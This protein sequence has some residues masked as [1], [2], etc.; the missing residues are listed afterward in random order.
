MLKV[1]I[2]YSHAQGTWVHD[3]LAPCLKAAGAEVL[4]DVD[5][6]QLGKGVVGQ[7]NA[8]QDMA[9]RH[10]LVL[11]K[12]YLASDYCQH[13]MKR[14][15]KLDAKLDK[16]L[17]L[18]LLRVDC[19]LPKPFSG[20]NP[21]LYAKFIDD[22]QPEPWLKL[23][24]SCAA[25][26]LGATAPDWLKAR[27]EIAQKLSR[28]ISVNLLTRPGSN[29]PALL[30]QLKENHFPGMGVINLEDPD[31]VTRRGLMTAICKDLGHA[32]PLPEEPYDLSGFKAVLQARTMTHIAITHFDLVPHR[33]SFDVDFFAALRYFIMDQRKLT[34]LIQS[35]SALAT[36]LP[37]DH[38][39]SNINNAYIELIGKP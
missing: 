16:G 15:L 29:W 18:P 39:L 24:A 7:M 13:E 8:V 3:R 25:H 35:R 4:L 31:T 11:S 10:I 27:D 22:S 26:E 17:V 37:K 5:R 34:L 36:L 30:S 20:W 14:A 2:S 19:S 33:P 23:F 21:A 9:D 32:T 38:P 6:F 28:D 1:F 12:D